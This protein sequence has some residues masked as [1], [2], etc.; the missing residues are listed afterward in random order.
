[1]PPLVTSRS[2]NSPK[3]SKSFSRVNSFK[4]DWGDDDALAKRS[5]L[6]GSS[7]EMDWLPSP[8]RRVN[9]T[10]T[11]VWDTESIP[12]D[13]AEDASHTIPTTDESERNGR[14][15]AAEGYP[16]FHEPEHPACLV[17]QVLHPF[18]TTDSTQHPFRPESTPSS[19][20]AFYTF[21]KH[22]PCLGSKE[23]A[24]TMGGGYDVSQLWTM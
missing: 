8:E 14:R 15:P 11:L 4:R 7:Q 6:K 22:I 1:M 19:A 10:R 5:G 24:I 9:L 13:Q 3:Q 12:Q 23:E 21:D 2:A 16:R 20:T 17:L 18:S